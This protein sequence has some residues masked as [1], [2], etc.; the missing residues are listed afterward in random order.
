MQQCRQTRLQQGFTLIIDDS[1]QSAKGARYANAK[2]GV[3]QPESEGN[4]LA[5][6]AKQIMV[7]CY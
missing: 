7:W 3:Q 1:G 4:T 6:L 5:K 2:L